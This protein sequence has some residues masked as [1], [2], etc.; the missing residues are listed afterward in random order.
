MSAEAAAQRRH[1][2]YAFVTVANDID[3]LS[4]ASR[5]RWRN[6]QDLTAAQGHTAWQRSSGGMSKLLA[7]FAAAL[8]D[9]SSVSSI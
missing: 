1:E 5:A 2:G 8:A 4:R 7:N 3:V 6:F 9:G